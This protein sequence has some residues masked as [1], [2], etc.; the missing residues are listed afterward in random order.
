M[1]SYVTISNEQFREKTLNDLKMKIAG[2]KKSAEQILDKNYF[3]RPSAYN[4]TKEIRDAEVLVILFKLKN[5]IINI[6]LDDLFNLEYILN[7]NM[8][9]R[10]DKINNG[11]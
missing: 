10:V 4:F 8:K 2:L 6:S 7:I 5:S 9:N 1:Q 11:G 3:D